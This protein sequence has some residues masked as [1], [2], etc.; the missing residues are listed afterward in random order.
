MVDTVFDYISQTPDHIEFTVKCSMVEIYMEKI[1]DLFTPEKTNLKIREDKA[2]GVYIEDV[3]EYYVSQEQDVYDLMKLGDSHRAV[4]ATQMNE[5]SS[6]SHMLFMMSIHQNNL[7]EMSAKTG[8]LYLV[9]LAG[10]EKVGKTGAAGQTLEEAKKI[11]QSLSA[12]GNVINALT[13]GKGHSHIP[14][15]NSKLTRVLQESLGGNARTTLIIT[16]SPSSFNDAETLSTLRFGYRAKSIKNK[17]KINREYTVAEL[18]LLLEKAENTIKQKEKRIKYLEALLEKH[19]IPIPSEDELRTS[20]PIEEAEKEDSEEKA[21]SDDESAE[22]ESSSEDED[23]PKKYTN[24]GISVLNNDDQ[25]RVK[26][27]CFD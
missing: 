14:Y 17:P 20:E 13:D 23:P 18:Q 4:T 21:K 8:K 22:E 19:N 7:H 1:R 26:P 9:D 6:R 27:I 5:G 24:I 11:N 2:R 10:S 12:L 3:T 16:C 25:T 15:R